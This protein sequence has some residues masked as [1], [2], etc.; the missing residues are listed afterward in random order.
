MGKH[1]VGFC[2]GRFHIYPNDTN[3]GQQQFTKIP[4]HIWQ[5]RCTFMIFGACMILLNFA[6]AGPGLQ[7]INYTSKSIRSLNRDLKDLITQ[8][9]LIMDQV[10][11]VKWNIDAIDVES[12]LDVEEA[13]PNLENN[14]FISNKVLRSSIRGLDREFEQLK[15]YLDGS[16]F[17]GIRGHV[18][19]LRDG[20]DAIDTA[21]TTVEKND[22]IVRMFTL[23]LSVFSAFM[24][25]ASCASLVGKSCYLPALQC[26]TEV[27]ILPMFV[28]G[29]IGSWCATSALAFASVSNAGKFR[30]FFLAVDVEWDTLHFSSNNMHVFFITDFCTGNS[31]ESGPAGTVMD[32]FEERGITSDDMIFIAFQYFQ[33]VRSLFFSIIHTCIDM[34]NVF[35]ISSKYGSSIR[36]AV[37]QRIL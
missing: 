36:R 7:S 24:I 31:M 17:E 15:V 4:S 21:M 30:L 16:D 9:L 6:L 19:Y 2:A 14:T 28:I 23:V 5:L 33:S 1:R 29:I 13:C 34:C 12:I 37:K 27:F 25:F 35:V 10:K 11:H 26:M 22:W 18:D 8:G 3:K 32:I 20:T